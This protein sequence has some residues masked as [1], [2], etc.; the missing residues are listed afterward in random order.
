MSKAPEQPQGL[1]GGR[2]LTAWR[3]VL[4]GVIT[5]AI[6]G[7][8]S[9]NGLEPKGYDAAARPAGTPGD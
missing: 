9:F 5:V 7:W 8:L 1:H 4:A 6:V 3:P 2:S